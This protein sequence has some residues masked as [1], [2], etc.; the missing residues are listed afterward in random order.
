[1]KRMITQELINLVEAMVKS[2]TIGDLIAQKV[3]LQNLDDLT[4]SDYG[5]L[6]PTPSDDKLL[7]WDG[8]VLKNVDV[9]KG[10]DVDSIDFSVSDFGGTGQLPAESET[11]LSEETIATYTNL[12]KAL[13]KKGFVVYANNALCLSM[14]N[15]NNI[16]GEISAT[17]GMVIPTE[18]QYQVD[19]MITG[20]EYLFHYI[21][22]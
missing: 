2:G 21:Q 19:L 12:I 9:I 13:I 5:A 11:S 17:F 7:A 16:T 14:F 1:M 20:D 18:A 10:Y 3:H 4:Y 15:F 22:M 6:F 8:G